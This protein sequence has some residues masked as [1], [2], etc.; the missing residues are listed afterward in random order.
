MMSRIMPMQKELLLR[1]LEAIAEEVR[2]EETDISECLSWS[3]GI[4][5][6]FKCEVQIVLQQ[7]G[8]VD[9]DFSLFGN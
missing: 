5:N 8:F 4:T 7:R 9:I 2:K 3:K 1:R 6:V